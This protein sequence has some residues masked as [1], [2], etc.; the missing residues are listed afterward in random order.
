[1]KGVPPLKTV[2]YTK[3]LQ[4]LPASAGMQM[5][6]LQL[7][8]QDTRYK[9]CAASY[10]YAV[11][12]KRPRR[13]TEISI[14]QGT[15]GSGGSCPVLPPTLNMG[16]LKR[17]MEFMRA[18][19]LRRCCPQTHWEWQTEDDKEAKQR[20]EQSRW[21]EEAAGSREQGRVPLSCLQS[22]ANLFKS[23]PLLN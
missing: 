11:M 19:G 1:M 6:Q 23:G 18:Q 4:L 20:E 22:F 14:Y 3:D 21:Q 16:L 5:K 17:H 8:I 12:W 7:Q 13:E 10:R 15:D 9:R 2:S